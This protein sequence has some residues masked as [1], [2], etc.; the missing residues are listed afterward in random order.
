MVLRCSPSESGAGLG[1]PALLLA[2]EKEIAQVDEEPAALADDEDGISAVDGIGQEHQ[3]AADGE[4]PERHRDD[5]F[6]PFLGGDPLDEKTHE[7][8][9]LPEEAHC[10]PEMLAAHFPHAPAC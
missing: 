4:V 6:L 3:P 2:D 5:A 9:C 8:E 1:E 10:H 7:E